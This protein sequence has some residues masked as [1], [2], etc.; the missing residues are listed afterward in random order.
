MGSLLTKVIKGNEYLY[1]V[2]S[3]RVK[4]RIIQKTIKYVGK[5]RPINKNE[6]ELDLR[7]YVIEGTNF[8]RLHPVNSFTIIGLKV[9][10][11]KR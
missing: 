9:N 1:L 10:L 11:E 5:K 8:I 4:D 2:D 7:D 3:I 6:F